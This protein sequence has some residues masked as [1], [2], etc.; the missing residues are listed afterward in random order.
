M[1]HL[2]RGLL[3]ASSGIEVRDATKHS[4]MHRT[5]ATIYYLAPN[6]KSVETGKACFRPSRPTLL[7]HPDWVC[8]WGGGYIP[9]KD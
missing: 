6:V 7:K 8:V 1:S 9:E 2:G 3:L 4:A 5:V